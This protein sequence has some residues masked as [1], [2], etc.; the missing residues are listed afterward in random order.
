MTRGGEQ[1]FPAGVAHPRG[2]EPLTSAFGGQRS[3][4][5][6]YGC[7]RV[8]LVGTDASGNPD[9]GTGKRL[10]V[11]LHLAVSETVDEM[12]VHHPDRL[13]VGVDDGRSDEA[14]TALLQILAE[15]VGLK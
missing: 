8:H 14:E 9:Q 5:L 11:P 15:S 7:V 1:P 4:Q 10:I 13:H 12:V 2:F 6:S 3:I